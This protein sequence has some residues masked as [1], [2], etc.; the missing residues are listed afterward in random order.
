MENIPLINTDDVSFI[1]NIDVI[2][3]IS[4]DNEILKRIET[5]IKT[6]VKESNNL[7]NISIIRKEIFELLEIIDE[8][9]KELSRFTSYEIQDMFTDKFSAIYS[10]SQNNLPPLVYF[11]ILI[12]AKINNEGILSGLFNND[13]SN[14]SISIDVYLDE[15]FYYLGIRKE[16]DF[17]I[18]EFIM[19]L[20]AYLRM[21]EEE[22]NVKTPLIIKKE[23]ALSRIDKCKTY[24]YI[25]LFVLF[26]ISVGIFIYFVDI[27][28]ENY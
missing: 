10:L 13:N 8:H 19:Y 26:L 23:R 9:N 24:T 2:V 14:N 15:K 17:K 5:L 4:N 12:E 6:I 20:S 25:C 18:N 21:K 11:R 22:C 16:I 1:E 28:E 3:N 27:N 7:H